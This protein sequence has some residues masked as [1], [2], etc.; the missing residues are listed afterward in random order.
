MEIELYH[1]RRFSALDA[2]QFEPWQ[3]TRASYRIARRGS[4]E[5]FFGAESYTRACSSLLINS[6]AKPTLWR[7]S[8][9]LTAHWQWRPLQWACLTQND[10]DSWRWAGRAASCGADNWQ[11]GSRHV[12]KPASPL[13]PSVFFF[14]QIYF[15][16]AVS[17]LVFAL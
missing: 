10:T 3:P 15:A 5:V 16:L 6:R 4:L 17:G 11:Q 12:T 2:P 9:V 13:A 14:N 1:L 7:T 8:V